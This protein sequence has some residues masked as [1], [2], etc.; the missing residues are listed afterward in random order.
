MT[1]ETVKVG[2]NAPPAKLGFTILLRVFMAKVNTTSFVMKG[3]VRKICENSLNIT[4]TDHRTDRGV[5]CRPSGHRG[6]QHSPTGSGVRVPVNTD[7]GGW[8]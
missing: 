6:F 2:Y 5:R 7:K 1:I 8:S 3:E 4:N